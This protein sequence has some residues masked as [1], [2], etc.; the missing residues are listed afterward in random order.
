MKSFSS[1]AT[2]IKTIIDSLKHYTIA[3]ILLAITLPLAPIALLN[4]GFMS[5]MILMLKFMIFMNGMGS[6]R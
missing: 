6:G 3:V 2:G 1:F 5:L 4:V